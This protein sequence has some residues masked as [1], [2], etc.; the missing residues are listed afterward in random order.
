MRLYRRRGQRVL[1]T[2]RRGTTGSQTLEGGV[3]LWVR[4]SECR[5]TYHLCDGASTLAVAISTTLVVGG[6]LG[7]LDGDGRG[8]DNGVGVHCSLDMRA[9]TRRYCEWM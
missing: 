2:R 8:E 1:G 7:L 3:S 6:D 4:E 9:N 5:E